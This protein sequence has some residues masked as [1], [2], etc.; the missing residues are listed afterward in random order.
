M[1]TVIKQGDS[2]HLFLWPYSDFGTLWCC[3]T[4]DREEV[5]RLKSFIHQSLPLFTGIFLSC[6]TRVAWSVTGV[7]NTYQAVT[8]LWRMTI[9]NM[10]CHQL[11]SQSWDKNWF[12]PRPPV[13]FLLYQLSPKNKNTYQIQSPSNVQCSLMFVFFLGCYGAANHQK[14][15]SNRTCPLLNDKTPNHSN[16]WNMLLIHFPS[17]RVYV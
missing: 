15:Q 12:E 14:L 16:I 7:S 10:C 11:H 5:F 17:Y 4:G 1:E 13:Y 9:C 3:C 8:G 6:S 2:S